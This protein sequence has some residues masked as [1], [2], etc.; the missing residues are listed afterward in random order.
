MEMEFF[1][2]LELGWLNGWILLC[3]WFVIQGLSVVILS[4]DVRSRLFEFDRSNWSKGHRVSFASGKIIGVVFLI[5]A[6]LTPLEFD[7]IEFF[8]G[9]G[10]Y[11]IGLSGLFSAV[12]SFG[13]TPLDQPAA[14]GLY[15]YSRHPQLVMLF[16]IGIGVAI[17]LGSWILLLLRILS[18][19]FEHA[20]VI[21]EEHECLKRFGE[22]YKEYMKRVPRYFLI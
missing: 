13:S 11:I 8:I 17:A 2:T 15:K 1:P 7:T 21:A 19:G 22:S 4:K 5:V 10:I 3:L 6:A 16:I 9:L 18:F 14:T 12:H 20:G